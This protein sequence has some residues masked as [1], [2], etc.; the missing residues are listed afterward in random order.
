MALSHTFITAITEPRD[1]L[2]GAA[3]RAVSVEA[4]LTPAAI[5]AKAEAALAKA[6][7]ATFAAYAQDQA[8]DPVGGI[9]KELGAAGAGGEVAMPADV[10]A[11]LTA[12]V[13]VDAARSLGSRAVNPDSVLLSPDPLLAPKKQAGPDDDA[14]DLSPPSRF[15]LAT[16]IAVCV[17]IA[18]T[19]YIVSR[20]GTPS[21][22]TTYPVP[23]SS[24]GAI[25]TAPA[26]AP[27]ATAPSAATAP[28][29]STPTTGMAPAAATTS[30]PA[31]Q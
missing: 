11:R 3:V 7:R 27:M 15:L 25:G 4:Q 21:G 20:N 29:T 2:Y 17:G 24:R 26:G 16:A 6:T 10:W 5:S 14:F 31:T 23:A 28:S 12:A 13:Q 18:L 30:A 22:P 1:R 9:E 19:V 8:V